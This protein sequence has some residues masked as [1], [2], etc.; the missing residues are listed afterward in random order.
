MKNYNIAVFSELLYLLC[1]RQEI[2]GVDELAFAS[3]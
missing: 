1:E 2:N 3:G